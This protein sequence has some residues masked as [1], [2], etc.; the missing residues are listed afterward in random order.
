MQEIFISTLQHSKEMYE[1]SLPHSQFDLVH[2]INHKSYK[3]IETQLR[4]STTERILDI[5]L[6]DSCSWDNDIAH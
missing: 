3:N 1:Q 5:T 2:Q 4:Q 6:V